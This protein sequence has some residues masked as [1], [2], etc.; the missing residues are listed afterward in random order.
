[1]IISHKY[2]FIFLKTKK[3]AGTS[4]EISLSR[5]CGESD[6]ITPIYLPDEKIREALGN[7]P[8]NYQ[9]G[10]KNFYNHI[11]A[12]EIKALI[13]EEIWNSYYK[14]C[15]DRNPWD[16]VISLYYFNVKDLK[17]E[18]FDEF[19]ERGKYKGAYNFPI[20]TTNNYPVVNYIGKYERLQNDLRSICNKIDLPFDGWLPKA[21]GNFRKNRQHY[22]TQYN[23]SQ[24]EIIQNY[25]KKE[26][27]LLN[28]K[29]F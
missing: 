5:Y 1:M 18:S 25:F 9:M 22:S 11:S 19:L 3:T 4:I 26:I 6:I 20:Y 13:G 14:F 8:Q 16:K 17:K 12:N 24:K 29:Y 2:K 27:D 21:K 23:K 28:Y 15:F 10:H 7:S